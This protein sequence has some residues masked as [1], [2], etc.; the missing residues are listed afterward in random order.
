MRAW[1]RVDFFFFFFGRR[2]GNPNIDECT[3][4]VTERMFLFSRLLGSFLFSHYKT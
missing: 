3:D 4:G 2:L 1:T